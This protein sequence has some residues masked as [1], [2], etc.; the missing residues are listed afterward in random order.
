MDW[1]EDQKD[2]GDHCKR[3]AEF[4]NKC[5]SV[6]GPHHCTLQ[7]YPFQPSLHVSAKVLH[8]FMIRL[9]TLKTRINRL[10]IDYLLFMQLNKCLED[11]SDWFLITYCN[12]ECFQVLSSWS[13]WISLMSHLF[14]FEYIQIEARMLVY[15]FLG[16]YICFNTTLIKRPRPSVQKILLCIFKLQN[17]LSQQ[18]E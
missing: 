12:N 2:Q 3:S 1:W 5:L 17:W 16:T 13:N 11:W 18:L 10:I 14:C 8:M 9:C 6:P 15:I 4:S 7:Q